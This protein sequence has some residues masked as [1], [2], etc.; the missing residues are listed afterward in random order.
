MY[1][2]QLVWRAEREEDS[3]G[4]VVLMHWLDSSHLFEIAF[5]TFPGLF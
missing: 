4:E 1:R 3:T 5:K 2:V